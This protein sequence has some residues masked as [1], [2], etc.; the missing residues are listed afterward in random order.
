M[1]QEVNQ[2]TKSH[3]S[4]TILSVWMGFQKCPLLV[5]PCVSLQLTETFQQYCA[6]CRL[7]EKLE[8][9][10]DFFFRCP[11]SAVRTVFSADFGPE[12][13]A[14]SEPC[15]WLHSPPLSA[16]GFLKFCLVSGD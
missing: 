2:S 10:R 8:C 16:P 4:A 15:V 1:P 3:R 11:L 12:Q 14:Q 7:L 9:M 5:T 6:H 13:D